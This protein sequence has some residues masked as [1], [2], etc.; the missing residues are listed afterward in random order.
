M[1]VGRVRWGPVAVMVTVTFA[2]M[3]IAVALSNEPPT[4]VATD[5][6][7]SS[8]SAARRRTEG[9]TR[10]TGAE[11][12]GTTTATSQATTTTPTPR[13]PSDQAKL[14]KVTTIGGAISPKSV[15][16]SGRGT[17][18]AQNMMYRHTVTVY[19]SD[20]T[21]ITT[22]PDT[23][24]LAALGHPQHQ[25]SFKGAPVEAAF[26]PDGRYEYVTNYSMYGPGFGPE[27]SDTCQPS[28]GFDNSYV[29]R[30]DTR[31]W[32]IDQAIEVGAVP[33][34]I[35]ITPDGKRLL[36][37]NWCSY[38]LSV[39]DVATAKVTSTI[40]LGAYPR[41]IAIT[42]D[43]KRAYVAIMGTTTIAQVN[44]TN[45]EFITFAAGGRGPRHIVLS[46]DDRWLYATLNGTGVVVKI[47][48]TNRAVVNTVRTGNNP[49]SMAIS[50]DGTAL[51]VVNYKSDTMTKLRAVDM[52]ELQT[53]AT[54]HHPIGITYDTHTNRV[55][56]ACYGGTIIVFD[57]K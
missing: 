11:P 13:V 35:A 40:T 52:T 16:A 45:M 1:Q 56:V 44:L 34:Y 6:D 39:I 10:T 43:S 51:Y 3:A 47:D 23:V 12:S 25:G 31:T 8:S 57:D 28:S 26:T 14:T 19:G 49:R 53:I 27:G 38:S 54:N 55:W 4:T 7:V 30:I 42:A 18:T 22:I 36:V 41:G 20:T 48:T 29:Y 9:T 17:V 50:A 32:K 37:T 24:D 33:K 46:P 21:L 5:S 2:I 15:V